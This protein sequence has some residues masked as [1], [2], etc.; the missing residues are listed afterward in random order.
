MTTK[1]T[2]IDRMKKVFAIMM[3]AAAL[4]IAAPNSVQAQCTPSYPAELHLGE[5]ACIQ[6]CQFGLINFFLVGADLDQAGIPVI[7]AV[8][9]CNPSSSDC[10]VACQ[11]ITPPSIFTL[12]GGIFFPSPTDWSG[13]SDCMEIAYRWNHDGYWEIEIFSLCSGCF[14]LSFDDQ[15]AA[16]V[17]SF[18]AVAGDRQVTVNFSTVSETDLDH[19]NILRDGVKATEIAATNSTAGHS[20]SWVDNGVTNGVTYTYT[21]ESVDVNGSSEVLAA[22]SAT[23]D[24]PNGVVAKFALDQNFP[25]PFNPE[26]NISFELAEASNVSLRIFNLVGQEV[27]TLVSGPQAAGRH[28]VNFDA[29]SLTSGMYIYRLEAGAFSATRKMI[30]MK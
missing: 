21:L 15:L 2:E 26:T 8:A 3:L 11:P 29:S 19:F 22:T 4:F 6:V 17:A 25:N 9:G 10:D 16:E 13:F 23:P 1:T 14:C 20:Y 7:T 5:S 12:G 30:L 18:D 24:A 27:A 28:T